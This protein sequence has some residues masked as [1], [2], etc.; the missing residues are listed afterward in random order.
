M[1]GSQHPNRPTFPQFQPTPGQAPQ[2]AQVPT[3][4]MRL[5][6]IVRA[7]SAPTIAIGVTLLVTDQ[8]MP[9]PLKPSHWIGGMYGRTVASESE[10]AQD[11]LAA[12]ARKQAEAQTLP[13]VLAQRVDKSLETQTTV[14]NLADF[15]CILG[16]FMPRDD[17]ENPD[18]SKVGAA[19]RTQGCALGNAMR[20][21]MQETIRRE[22]VQPVVRPMQP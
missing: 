2:P 13:P 1:N 7:I 19:M 8:L 20:D 15:A 22:T 16:Q 5:V 6:G 4:L 11:M 21:N 17:P 10:A 12:Q 3:A 14:A 9:A 18:L